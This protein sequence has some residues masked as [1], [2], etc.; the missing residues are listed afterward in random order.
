MARTIINLHL[1]QGTIVDL[2]GVTWL[3]YCDGCLIGAFLQKFDLLA[4]NLDPRI[5]LDEVNP[6]FERWLNGLNEN[7][8]K[9]FINALA[10]AICVLTKS[11]TAMMG[12]TIIEE[13]Q[14]MFS[15]AI[16]ALIQGNVQQAYHLLAEQ[17]YH[18]PT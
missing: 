13:Y 18:R 2:I 4:N 7:E 3:R 12:H 15:K 14:E 9:N 16:G 6:E 5:H 8:R 11:Y 1:S 10:N 17:W